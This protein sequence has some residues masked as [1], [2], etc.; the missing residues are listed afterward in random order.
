MGV[1]PVALKQPRARLAVLQHQLAKLP[2]G[3]LVA[4]VAHMQCDAPGQLKPCL[5]QQHQRQAAGM[6][7]VVHH[8]RQKSTA[9]RLGDARQRRVQRLVKRLVQPAHQCVGRDAAGAVVHGH[10]LH[11]GGAQRHACVF[12]VD[13]DHVRLLRHMKTGQLH[14]LGAEQIKLHRAQHRALLQRPQ[15]RLCVGAVGQRGHGRKAHAARCGGHAG[16]H[17]RIVLGYLIAQLLL[18][19]GPAHLGQ[20]QRLG[21]GLDVARHHH[22]RRARNGLLLHTGHC[23]QLRGGCNCFKISSYQRLW[24]KR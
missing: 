6:E 10:L 17:Q 14:R 7:L 2:R 12:H 13:L 9:L 20:H 21:A 8:G 18:L 11:I 15:R 22:L 4:Q 23:Q 5:R 3:R 24:G 1:Q 16:G 19:F